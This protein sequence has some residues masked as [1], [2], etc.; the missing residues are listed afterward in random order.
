MRRRQAVD[1]V[2]CH[3]HHAPANCAL[4]RRIITLPFSLY[5]AAS[6]F[7]NRKESGEPGPNHL[8]P[9]L[10]RKNLTGDRLREL[11]NGGRVRRL[12][13][14]DG[15]PG[16]GDRDSVR[17]RAR[18][19]GRAG[20]SP[21]GAVAAELAVEQVRCAA[22]RARNV[23]HERF[24]VR[25]L[26][27][28]DG[29]IARD[30]EPGETTCV[31]AAR[32]R[33]GIAGAKVSDSVA[34]LIQGDGSKDLTARQRQKPCLG[35]AASVPVGFRERRPEGTLLLATDGLVN[36]ADRQRL[37]AIAAEDDPETAARRLVDSAR[38]QPGG[39][40]DDVAVVLCRRG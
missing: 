6:S 31:V 1:R 29:T 14:G 24:W 20:G 37:A 25:I 26:R 16:R 13:V 2:S 18:R 7:V 40:S 21:G 10:A 27:E 33:S 39:L 38:R 19:R 9:A 12:S 17:S 23:L 5:T 22:A 8:A 34:W 4:C 32:T 28:I 36:Y 30:P 35:T 11:R 15:G 3:H